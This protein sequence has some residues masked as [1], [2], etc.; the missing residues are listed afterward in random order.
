MVRRTAVFPA[1]SANFHFHRRNRWCPDAQSP[2]QADLK[3]KYSGDVEGD[4]WSFCG[5]CAATGGVVWVQISLERQLRKILAAR[6]ADTA[7]LG[8]HNG[9]PLLNH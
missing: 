5:F 7:A 8:Y 6:G 2:V 4:K 9:V 1:A 3:S